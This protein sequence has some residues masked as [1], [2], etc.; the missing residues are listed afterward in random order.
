MSIKNF[1]IHVNKNGKIHKSPLYLNNN[2]LSFIP[3]KDSEVCDVVLVSDNGKVSDYCINNKVY[4]VC[5]VLNNKLYNVHYVDDNLIISDSNDKQNRIFVFFR[6]ENHF[7]EQNTNMTGFLFYH[8]DIL[9]NSKLLCFNNSNLV[10]LHTKNGESDNILSKPCKPNCKNKKCGDDDGCGDK[11]KTNCGNNS[12]NG[13]KG[14]D[15]NYKV[16]LWILFIILIIC[17]ILL[18][19]I[20]VK[21]VNLYKNKNIVNNTV[22]TNVNVE[23]LL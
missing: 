11:C 22:Q 13:N 7:M 18:I 20:I 6:G 16:L 5:V 4:Y 10:T 12:N 23:N 9:G 19:F 14:N 8:G 1:Y 17:T 2:L 3:E 21:T 15:K